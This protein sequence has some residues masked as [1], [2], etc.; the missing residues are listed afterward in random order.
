MATTLRTGASVHA[1]LLVESG[2]PL[3]DACR[4]K[5]TLQGRHRVSASGRAAEHLD[6]LC[7]DGAIRS[8]APAAVH[9][10]DDCPRKAKRGEP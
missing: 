3:G 4:Y 1:A 8:F 7:Q 9:H 5:G 2:G 6:V 10:T